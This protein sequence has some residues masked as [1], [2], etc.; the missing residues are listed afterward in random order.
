MKLSLLS[1]LA[2]GT[3]LGAASVFGGYK[4]SEYDYERK[5]PLHAIEVEHDTFLIGS[6]QRI[7]NIVNLRNFDNGDNELSIE[8]AKNLIVRIADLD[9]DDSV[10]TKQ[11]KLEF[12]MKV[13]KDIKAELCSHG[14]HRN[15]EQANEN[16]D[17][18][19]EQVINQVVEQKG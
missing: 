8:E 1:K 17:K 10:Y 6:G 13:I 11:K 2:V 7:S 19:I 12:A 3:T 14:S 15:Y 9:K 5:F 18:A 4:L 16:L